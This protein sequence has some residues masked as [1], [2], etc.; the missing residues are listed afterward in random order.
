MR[1]KIAYRLKTTQVHVARNRRTIPRGV[2]RSGR[3]GWPLLTE[4]Q[5]AAQYCDGLAEDARKRWRVTVASGAA[6]DALASCGYLRAP[7]ASNGTNKAIAL[8][9]V[10]IQTC[11]GPPAVQ[12]ASFP[13]WIL[14]LRN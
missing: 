13:S 4:G 1:I 3:C 11:V 2:C 10:A 14:S 5:I 8:R 7:S 12:P 9:I 6:G